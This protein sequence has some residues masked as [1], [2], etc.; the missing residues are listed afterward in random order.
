MTKLFV[1]NLSF[2]TREPDLAKFFE[3]IGP[4]FV[5]S[6]LFYLFLI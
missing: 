3:S 4:V 6:F 5:F 1:G 2:K